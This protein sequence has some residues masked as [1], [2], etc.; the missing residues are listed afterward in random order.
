MNIDERENEDLRHVVR[1]GTGQ[2]LN[3][4]VLFVCGV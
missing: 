3:P 2:V 1:S 4:A